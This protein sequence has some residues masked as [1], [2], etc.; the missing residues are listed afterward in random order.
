MIFNNDPDFLFVM[1]HFKTSTFPAFGGGD[2]AWAQSNNGNSFN[3]G[4]KCWLDTPSTNPHQII[5]SFITVDYYEKPN[6][7]KILD[8]VAALNALQNSR[9]NLP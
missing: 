3:H 9:L 8:N 4:K 6:R 5:P 7:Q 1:N 2:E